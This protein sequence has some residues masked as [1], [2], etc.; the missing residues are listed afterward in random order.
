MPERCIGPIDLAKTADDRLS[1]AWEL[2]RET[3]TVWTW[4][5]GRLLRPALL[6]GCLV[7]GGAI[8]LAVLPGAISR[9]KTIPEKPRPRSTDPNLF[10]PTEAQWASLT[11]EECTPRMF[12]SVMATD[13]KIAID[14]DNATPVFSPY[15]GRVVRLF[16]KAGDRIEQG[17]PLF[18]VEAA[19]MVQGQ[20]DFLNALTGLN[21]AKATQRMTDVAFK[22]HKELVQFNAVAKRDLEQAEAANVNAENDTKS[23]EAVLQAARNR[24]RI[25]GKSDAE[26]DSFEKDGRISAETLIVAPLT[27]TVVLRKVGPGQFVGNGSSDPVFV[28]GD[29]ARVWLVANVRESDATSVAVGQPVEFSI[30]AAPDRVFKATVVYIAPSVNPDTRRLQVRA[31][32]PNPEGI[33]RPEMFANVAIVT[34]AASSPSLPR[35]ALIY[36]GDA[37]RVWV[38][39]QDHSLELRRISTGLTNGGYVQVL[40]GLR[41]GELVVT[42]GGLFVDRL[43]QEPGP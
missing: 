42:Q 20:N 40:A 27:G 12:R 14:E 31:E 4:R 3:R 26:I 37:A 13:G 1:P 15:A 6:T 33:L 16:A 10:R 8:A 11:I 22:R 34:G 30:L 25:L 17:R 41:A 5:R 21:K 18:A 7:A 39:G 38:A 19:D 29:L 36:E 2:G 28:V 24:L 23:A 35:H 9:A 43:A 32:V